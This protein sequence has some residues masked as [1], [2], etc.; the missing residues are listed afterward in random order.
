ML[1]T[2]MNIVIPGKIQGKTV[3]GI[4]NSAFEGNEKITSVTISNG[5]TS[6]GDG[7]FFWM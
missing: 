5:V 7:A 4:E 1:G 6:I 3:V 2:E